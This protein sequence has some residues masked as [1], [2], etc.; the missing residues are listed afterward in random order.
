VWLQTILVTN[1][2]LLFNFCYFVVEGAL[3]KVVVCSTLLRC[4]NG[5]DVQRG[6]DAG[7][8]CST[9]KVTLTFL[10]NSRLK[11]HSRT[12]LYLCVLI[13]LHSALGHDDS[14]PSYFT[15]ARLIQSAWLARVICF[16]IKH[17]NPILI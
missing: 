10:I 6:R 9:F 5:K 15:K 2:V 8:I 3:L 4:G 1:S 14:M 13:L 7:F 11:H 12:A 17:P 16:L